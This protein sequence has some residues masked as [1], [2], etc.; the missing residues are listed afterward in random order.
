[1]ESRRQKRM[2]VC[3][4]NSKSSDIFLFFSSLCSNSAS[5]NGALSG[6]LSPLVLTTCT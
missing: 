6:V 1:L 4:W 5:E 3:A 2:W